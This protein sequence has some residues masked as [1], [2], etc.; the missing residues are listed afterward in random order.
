[1]KTNTL[2]KRTTLSN[3]S[4]GLAFT[5]LIIGLYALVFSTAFAAVV[6]TI[7]TTIKNGSN[8]TVNTAPIGTQVRANALVSSS[9]GPTALGT[10]DFS[11]YPNTTCSGT[12]TSQNGVLL[13]S[14]SADS[15]T[16]TLTATGLSYRVRYNGQAD[17]YNVVD[18]SCVSLQPTS[19]SV[20]L[21]STL[22]STTVS[23]GTSVY[24]NSTL[25][26]LTT[27]ATG[28]VAYS[29]YTNNACNVGKVDAG[30][31]TISSGIVPQSNSIQFN[32]VGTLYWQAMYSGDQFNSVATG[33]CQSL[34]VLATT[35]TPTPTPTPT[36]PGTGSITG[37]V[38]NDVNTNFKRDAGEAGIGGFT[39]KLRGGLFWWMGKHKSPTV[40]TVTTDSNGVYTFGNLGDGIYM[41]EEIKLGEWV[42][43]SAD[44]KWVLVVNGKALTGLDFANATKAQY[45]AYKNGNKVDKE[46]KKEDKQVKKEE[47]KNK[48]ISKLQERIEK[49]KNR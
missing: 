42:Q 10:V 6:P 14:G 15:S 38:Y 49:I 44:Y 32:T 35:T 40:T 12:A 11:L 41:V 24:Q 3:L 46:K 20:S 18:G 34:S 28:T 17:V 16:T 8:S 13:A 36:N 45:D 5:G 43:M 1:M 19:G 47:Q 22:S 31:K 39:V 21:S 48:K 30:V 9:T 25:S 26:G 2:S 23:V 7:E 37:V 27:N 29:V 4:L 33:P